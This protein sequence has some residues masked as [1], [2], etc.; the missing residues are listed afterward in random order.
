[1]R[2]EIVIGPMFSGKSTELIRRCSRY[3]AVGRAVCI[4]NHSLDARCGDNMVQTHTNV[5]HSAIKRS[6]LSGVFG[7]KASVP[8]V[9]GIDEAQFFEDLYA[10]VQEMEGTNTVIIIAGLDGD[11]MRRPF[12]D[13]LTC[14]PLCDEITKLNAM[15]TECADG[16]PGIFSKRCKSTCIDIVHV[17]A[18]SEYKSVC[19]MHYN[20]P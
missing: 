14:I 6:S 8:D 12:G 11:F 13:I 3:K 18:S 15:C 20:D 4:I 5:K 1:M 9:I 17:G 19:R 16:T 2:L 7:D 10:F